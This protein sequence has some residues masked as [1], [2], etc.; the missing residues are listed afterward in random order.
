MVINKLSV[1]FLIN[2]NKQLNNVQILLIMK[3]DNNFSGNF[4]YYLLILVYRYQ[5]YFAKLL[6]LKFVVHFKIF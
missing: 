6:L 1:N 5:N 4:K 2:L 3:Y